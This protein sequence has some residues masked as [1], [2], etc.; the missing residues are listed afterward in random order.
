MRRQW[1]NRSR[2]RDFGARVALL[3][4]CCILGGSSVWGQ[5]AP[6]R[7]SPV[8]ANKAVVNKVAPVYP[9][10][11][12][13]MKLT[14][15]VRLDA[16]VDENGKVTSIKTLG[17]NPLLTAAARRALKQ[18]KFTPFERGGKPVKAIVQIAFNFQ[19]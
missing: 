2:G 11:A 10:M 13:Q 19:P 1:F 7:V 8:E 14:G 16:V 3:A 5:D 9:A 17:G 6:V 15:K 18:W 4:A 12:K